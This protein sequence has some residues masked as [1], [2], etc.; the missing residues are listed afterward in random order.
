MDPF[1]IFR[2]KTESDSITIV[3]ALL[4]LDR[5]NINDDFKRPFETYLNKLKEL[6][7]T[8]INMCIYIQK[9]H[10]NF[11]RENRE[12]FNT[13]IIFIEPDDLI[14]YF[15]FYPETQAIRLQP[16]WHS[17]AEWLEK[18]PQATLPFYNPLVMSKML[19]LEE[20]SEEN[21]FNSENFYW[22]DAGITS[23]VH[24][25]YFTHDK[26]LE[27]LPSVIKNFS[28]VCYPY[29]GNT[30][31]H[32]FRRKP[33]ADIAGVSYINRVARGGFF[34][35]HISSIKSVSDHYKA[36]LKDTLEKGLMGTEESIFTLLTYLHKQLDIF[37]IGADGFLSTFFEDMKTSSPNKT[38]PQTEEPQTLEIT[39]DDIEY[40]HRTSPVHFH[41]TVNTIKNY[42]DKEKP[43]CIIDIGASTGR[44]L[45]E[46]SKELN[47]A[48]AVL[49]EPYKA[50]SEYSKKLF[51]DNKNYKVEN[52]ALGNKKKDGWLS[53]SKGEGGN[54]G[55]LV[56]SDYPGE[57]TEAIEIDT[58]DS[59]IKKYAIENI[60]I[61]KIHT[62][63]Y[64]L[65]ILKGIGETLAS[66][67]T[68]PLIIF[69]YGYYDSKE[70][71]REVLKPFFKMGYHNYN[72]Y[73]FGG[74]DIVLLPD[75]FEA[76]EIELPKIL[77]ECNFKVSTYIITY[78]LPKQLSLL[79]NSF[80]DAGSYL[81]EN[82][83]KYLLNNSDDSSTDEAYSKLCEQYG[84]TEIK[85]GNLGICGGR[86]FIAEH[87][88]ESNAEH[89]FFFEDDMLLHTE[90]GSCANGLATLLPDLFQN[91]IEIL[92]HEQ[93]DFM[94]LSFSEFFGDNKTQWAWYNIPQTL[95]EQY[96]PEHLKLPEIGLSHN[97]PQTNF[98]SIKT[99]N[100]IS[101]LTGDIYYC[102]WP[103]V[104][105]QKGNKTMF[106]D[107]KWGHPYEQTWMSH[108]F[109]MTKSG[110]L[111]PG[112][113]LAS[114]INHNRV[115]H[116]D[117]K[118][119]KENNS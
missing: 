27:K 69:D 23:T 85:N 41:N 21:T 51:N 55:A 79:L 17:Q 60:D 112:L 90:K 53:I 78:N 37:Y 38:D 40:W 61:I 88:A 48:S 24:P 16:E 19:M 12:D 107:T 10:E 36:L 50:A 70:N 99:K 43:L 28:F 87:F 116:Y 114:P 65:E 102:N 57:N 92:E 25:G 3:T 108:F 49:I 72:A 74:G 62:G 103:Q 95:R 106:L 110:D 35:G 22:L 118:L 71:L 44:F 46:L 98:T 54:L 15:P 77:N 109:Q 105:S 8:D 58:F 84:F 66:M 39:S 101:Y 96:F 93:F 9:K 91:S 113:L 82:T 64:S 104:V 86:Q 68:Q 11:I 6:L 76:E 42:F 32:G 52:I 67:K 119:R 83:N 56:L 31:I 7:N 94:K 111:K 33:M 115:Y 63:N 75:S 5:G 26:V 81:L 2:K 59:I 18:S 45:Y 1:K 97:P 89:M 47:I 13:K 80:E 73:S 117:G 29:T 4:D 34:G 30:E 14:K 20:Q 100:G